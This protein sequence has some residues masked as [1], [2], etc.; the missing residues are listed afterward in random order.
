[1]QTSKPDIYAAGDV[2]NFPSRALEMRLRFEH[3]ITPKRWAEPP[4]PTWPDAAPRIST[5]Q[6]SIRISSISAEAVGHIDNRTTTVE[7][8]V[9]KFH[10]GVIYYMA[11]SRVRG[12]LLWN[13]WGQIEPARELIRSE[14]SYQHE[15][16]MVVCERIAEQR[17]HRSSPD[18]RDAS[19]A[20][21]RNRRETR[22]VQLQRTHNH[23]LIG[24]EPHM[25]DY[26]LHAVQSRP[27]KI[28]DRLV[29]SRFRNSITNGLAAVSEPQVAVCLLPGTE[30]AFDE[31]VKY[32]H[33]LLWF[34]YRALKER[35]ARFR[36][37]KASNPNTHHDALEFP[38]GAVVMVTNLLEHQTLTVLQLPAP[39]KRA[40][41]AQGNEVVPAQDV[42]L[43]LR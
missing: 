23:E 18:H 15:E 38:S 7:D 14:R 27:A 39:T 25:C 12:V 16:L 43:A 41:G 1:L 5:S 20:F 6:C 11:D 9:D 24:G 28:A 13:T 17:R 30:V 31:D 34:R 19:C 37:I 2:A 10:K 33:P 8:W 22:D 29:T 21:I 26:S 32:A 4:V 3:E 40:A 36:Q 42:P 35:V